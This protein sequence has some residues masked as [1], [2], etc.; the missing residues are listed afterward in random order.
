MNQ[1]TPPTEAI[2]PGE[3]IQLEVKGAFLEIDDTRNVL[4]PFIPESEGNPQIPIAGPMKIQEA[5][6]GDSVVI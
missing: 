1:F 3:T 4:R 2:A 5:E 6:P